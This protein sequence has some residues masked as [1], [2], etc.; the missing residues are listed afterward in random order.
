MDKILELSEPLRQWFQSLAR[1]EQLYLMVLAPL[2]I[3]Y[4]IYVLFWQPLVRENQQ[5]ATANSAAQLQLQ[6]VQQLSA[7]YRAL[8]AKGVH[9]VAEVNLPRLIDTSV[10]R[11]QLSLKRMQPS[12]SGDVQLRF[13]DVSFNQ[14]LAW[15]HELE[16]EYAVVVKDLSITP[17]DKAGMVSSSV[18]L[19]QG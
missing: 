5:L 14:L 10:A 13:E 12:A 8:Q 16:F 1:K 6:R 17:T 3:A 15:L 11:Y 2:L 18:R 4:I 19:R 9:G 7:E